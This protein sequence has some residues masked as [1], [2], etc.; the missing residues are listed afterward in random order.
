MASSPDEGALVESGAD[1]GYVLKA[2]SPRSLTVAVNRRDIGVE[3]LATLEFT[4]ERKRS[5]V[6]IRHPFSREIVLYC[7]GA[8]DF[9]LSH[10]APND[11]NVTKTKEHVQIFAD[12]GLR[13]LCCGYRILDED[14]FREW[15]A[16]FREANCAV[17]G[18][19]EEV[20]AVAAEVEKDLI[21]LGATAIEDKLQV[22]VP[23]TIEA[24]L[25]AK[26]S[27]WVITGD[28]RETAINIGFACSLLSNKMQL[29]IVDFP[30]PESI[31]AKLTEA[32]GLEGDLGLVV[33]GQSLQFLLEEPLASR[34]YEMALRCQSVICCRASPLQKARVVALMREKT[35]KLALAIGDGANDVGMILQADVGIGISGKEG[36]QAVLASDYAIAQFRF[37]GRLLLVHGRLNFY[38]NVDLINYSFYKNM[39]CSLCNVFIGFFSSWSGVTIFDSML[40]MTFNVI[41]TSA[42][43]VVYAGV[44]RDV[45]LESMQRLPELY[46]FDGN[47]EY[48]QSAQ[49]FGLSLGLGVLHAFIA[50]FVPYGALSPG[51][52]GTGRQVG[53]KEF[54]TTVYMCVVTLVNVELAITSNNF[55]WL[56]HVFYWL[57]IGICPIAALI[58]DAMRLSPD[59]SGTTVPVVGSAFFWFSVIAVTIFGAM[60]S[61]ARTALA[62]AMN[63][64]TVRVRWAQARYGSDNALGGSI[65]EMG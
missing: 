48:L 60:I 2:R 16:R 15:S 39:A 3:L 19:E 43:P 26:I 49:R 62:N 42:P 50:F 38:R 11:P 1:F 32:S 65:G 7:K 59:L 64:R 34:F 51:V 33:S 29:I 13:T 21:L 14:F 5:S 12:N 8:D 56:H 41:F 23:A 57:S 44:E 47:R 31:E 22:G 52:S 37:L 45:S 24:L 30:D 63:T 4:S 27:V 9:V 53:L 54:G 18:R 61:I 58:I 10:L 28:K 55:T 20:A 36:R 40:Y 46:D 17:V 35:G 6:I 25:R